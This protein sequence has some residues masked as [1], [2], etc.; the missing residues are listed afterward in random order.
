MVLFCTPG[1]TKFSLSGFTG[2][3]DAIFVSSSSEWCGFGKINIRHYN[4]F[5]T[6]DKINVKTKWAHFYYSVRLSN[7]GL[8][9]NRLNRT[10][11]REILIKMSL[12]EAMHLGISSGKWCPLCLSFNV[13]TWLM[14]FILGRHIS[15]HR[16]VC[17][18][19]VRTD[20][21]ETYHC[22]LYTYAGKMKAPR[23]A[24]LIDRKL[25]IYS[26]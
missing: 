11:I 13:L 19:L 8:L 6:H 16:P 4:I 5:I 15:Q 9:L 22:A 17:K 25:A 14:R 12:S 26:C 20:A 2:Y 10:H 1:C 23:R 21:F 7:D 24:Y 3:C 18:R